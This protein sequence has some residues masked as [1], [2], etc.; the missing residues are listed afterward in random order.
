VP[1]CVF[2]LQEVEQL[3]HVEPIDCVVDDDMREQ[4][5]SFL[6]ALCAASHR[7]S[8]G[9]YAGAAVVLGSMCPICLLQVGGQSYHAASWK[10]CEGRQKQITAESN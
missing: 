7:A 4:A 6:E 8:T 9:G 10:G 3:K 1:T 5:M 2:G